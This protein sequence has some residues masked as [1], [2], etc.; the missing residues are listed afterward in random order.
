M[1]KIG[2]LVSAV[3]VGVVL[4]VCATAQVPPVRLATLEWVPFTASNLPSKGL[5][6][7]IVSEVVKAM[8]TTLKI[9]FHPWTETVAKGESDPA[10]S[11]YFPV[12][13]TEE[14]AKKCYFSAPI[15][16]TVT[17]I[18]YLKD[19]PL[20]WKTPADLAALKIGVVEGYPNGE[21]FDAAV[22]QGKQP[23]EVTTSD[24]NNVKKLVTKKVP[25]I[26]IDKAVLR[27]MT[28]KTQ[29]KDSVA[30]ADKTL[31]ERTMHVCFQ[32]T[33]AGKSLQEAFDNALK[34]VDIGR[35]ES[36]YLKK[37]EDPGH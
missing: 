33:P 28:Y 2:L 9:D 25:A 6:G 34:K 31:V 23:V 21:A 1:T 14:R 16:K 37:I 29:A 24:T 27:Y 36:A 19:S 35:L 13:V 17:G 20:Q 3:W 4:P 10:F 11:G 32:R 12:W 22:K 26:V 7:E 5:S 18:G 30:F 8:G 15:G